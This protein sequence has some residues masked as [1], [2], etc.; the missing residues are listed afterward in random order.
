MFSSLLLFFGAVGA[1]GSG[2][3]YL[4]RKSKKDGSNISLGWVDQSRR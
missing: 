4:R 1:L 3:Y 2:A